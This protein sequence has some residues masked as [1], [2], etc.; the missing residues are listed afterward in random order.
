M[1]AN[2]AARDVPMDKDFSASSCR[3]KSVNNRCKIDAESA[4]RIHGP[5]NVRYS[6]SMVMRSAAQYRAPSVKH[7]TFFKVK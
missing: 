6:H 5:L 3:Q 4:V 7:I 2:K 1:H